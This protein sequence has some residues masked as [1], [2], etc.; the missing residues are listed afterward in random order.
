L[1]LIAVILAAPRPTGAKMSLTRA[2]HALCANENLSDPDSPRVILEKSGARGI[3]P[4]LEVMA[5]PGG[6]DCSDAW[7]IEI[8][9]LCN[10]QENTRV[11]RATPAFAPVR[12]ALASSDWRRVSAALDILLGLN[13]WTPGDPGIESLAG[14]PSSPVAQEFR[15]PYPFQLK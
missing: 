10:A 12:A 5:S 1:L 11:D 6:D 7:E 8:E 3:V 2:A 13:S 14:H 15:T 9:L 4:L